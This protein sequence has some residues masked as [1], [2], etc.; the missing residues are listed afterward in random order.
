M[1]EVVGDVVTAHRALA[2]AGQADLVWGHAAVRDPAGRGLW[3][4]AAGWGMEE[5]TPE[6]VVLLSDDGEVLAGEGPRHIEFHIHAALLRARPDASATVHTH[7]EAAAAFAALDVPLRPLSHDA[8][9]FADPDVA[10]F[11]R[12]SDLIATAALGDALAAA[13]G[14]AAGCLVPGHGLVTVGADVASAVMFAA[15]LERA[16]RI[17]LAAAGGG[18]PAIWTPD[19]EVRVKRESVWNA[20]QLDAG[21]R[22]L[23]RRA[24]ALY[25]PAGSG[26]SASSA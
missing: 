11:R 7:A 16:C 3:T 1:S 20:R 26:P 2:A 5:V 10:R 13:V 24:D 6:R 22:Y 17:Q 23:V 14:T 19:A 25:G 9:P 21:F 15:L 4:K 8:V 12:T 18:G